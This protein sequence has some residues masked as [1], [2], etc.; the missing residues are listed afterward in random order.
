MGTI[1][2]N[3]FI[4]ETRALLPTSENKYMLRF[5]WIIA[6]LIGVA[7]YFVLGFYCWAAIFVWSLIAWPL[8]RVSLK[9]QK[10]FDQT[11]QKSS[12]RRTL[13]IGGWLAL[14]TFIIG[15][16]LNWSPPSNTPMWIG[17][18]YAI[19]FTLLVGAQALYVIVITEWMVRRT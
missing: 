3:S 1:L 13:L 12:A 7:A 14:A 10:D 16:L 4:F 15:L 19:C 8:A 18:I 11:S 6:A 2:D 9:N 17:T 5:A